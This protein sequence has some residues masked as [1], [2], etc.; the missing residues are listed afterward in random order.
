MKAASPCE[1]LRNLDIVFPVL[2]GPFGEDGS[3]QGMLEA[4]GLPYVGC[5]VL[6]SA[7]GMDKVLMKTVFGAAGLP[8]GRYLWFFRDQWE[9]EAE[10]ITG[11]VTLTLGYPCFVKPAN[12]GS[13]VG[14]HRVK[15][16][17]ELAEAVRDALRFDRK[18]LIE[19]GIN[20]QEVECGV[21]GNADARA[22]VVGEILPAAEFYDYDSK[23]FVESETRIP[24]DLAPSEAERVRDLAVRAFRAID[25]RGI[26]RVDFFVD[27]DTREVLINEINT[28]PGFTRISMYPKL[29]EAAGIAYKDLCTMLIDYGLEDWNLRHRGSTK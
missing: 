8:Q 15:A 2:H 21:L 17:A 22:S 18:I 6:A 4:L 11:D 3:L 29:W 16:E 24:A 28:M 26:S 1:A 12:M 5:G 14:I 10:K 7:L 27:R 20:G 23:Y 13:S 25:G 19:K 9:A